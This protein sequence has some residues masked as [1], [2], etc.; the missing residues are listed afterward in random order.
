MSEYAPEPVYD[1]ASGELQGY[2]VEASD[3]AVVSVGLDGSIL[4]A[5]NP[6]TLEPLDPDGYQLADDD[7][8]EPEPDPRLAEYQQRLEALEQQRDQPQ[9]VAFERVPDQL[10]EARLSDDLSNQADY[11]ERM[12][13][14]PLTLAEK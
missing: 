2:L 6:E 3:G 8:G 11:L 9:P 10:D 5:V 7:D 13:D 14:R 4:G 12:L 1:E